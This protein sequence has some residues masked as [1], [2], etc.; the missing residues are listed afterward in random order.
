M[1]RFAPVRSAPSPFVSSEV[2]TR[3]SAGR[4]ANG[5]TLVEVMVALMIFG[6]IAS[7]GVG[8]LA[9]SVRAQA[10][11]TA[12]LDDIGALGRQSSLLAAD[13][14][15]AVNRPARDD[16][17]TLLP[18]FVGDAASVTFVRAGWSNIDGQ[19]RS[20]LQKVSYRID[21]DTLDRIAWPMVDG[22]AALPP[23]AALSG[24]RM[25]KLRYRIAGAWADRWDG[26][27]A[28]LPQ[29]LELFVERKDGLAFR[30]LFLVGSGAPPLPP[31]PSEAS[32]AA[33]PPTGNVQ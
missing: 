14:A 7:A 24:I 8:L 6:L 16:R 26:K 19:P 32:D 33:L 1:K 23:A 13:L 9:F 3:G 15:Q 11:T 21:G 4:A 30:Q 27:T 12:R 22:A 29:A 10:A 2:A 5:F 28:P 20:S 25:V 18:A 17:G 31:A